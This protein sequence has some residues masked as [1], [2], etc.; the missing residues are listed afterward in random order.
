MVQVSDVVA[1]GATSVENDC[2]RGPCVGGVAAGGFAFGFAA[3]HCS[4]GPMDAI[5]HVTQPCAYVWS[6]LRVVV[7]CVPKPPP[8][9][10]T[11]VNEVGTVLVPVPAAKERLLV[12]L[13]CRVCP[14]G[15]VIT[16]GAQD[17]ATTL[18]LEF[19]AAQ[20]AV[21]PVTTAPQA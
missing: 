18:G 6:G 21:D 1:P 15:T 2:T 16:T 20:V 17:P 9:W 4:P 14:V 11:I 19:S 13:I 3:L 5:G 7:R 8:N 12:R 10:P